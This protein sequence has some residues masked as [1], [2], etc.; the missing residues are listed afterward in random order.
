MSFKL[1]RKQSTNYLHRLL[2]WLN[3][4]KD[5]GLQALDVFKDTVLSEFKGLASDIGGEIS[6]IGNYDTKDVKGLLDNV[7]KD[8]IKELVEKV[9]PLIPEYYE[10]AR[11]MATDIF[12]QGKK[13]FDRIREE[14][15]NEVTSPFYW[16]AALW[17]LYGE[18]F[19]SHFD[20]PID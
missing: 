16:P 1:K 6:A 19:V 7:D 17:K 18:I 8:K 2:G 11:K 3:R 5:Y 14:V 20:N 13:E 15:E 4:G 10:K 12:N 9:K